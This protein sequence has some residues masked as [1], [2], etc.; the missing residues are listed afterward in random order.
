ME[1]TEETQ[2]SNIFTIMKAFSLKERNFTLTKK[3]IN[4][5]HLVYINE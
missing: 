3:L 5:S 2:N 4:N 1:W